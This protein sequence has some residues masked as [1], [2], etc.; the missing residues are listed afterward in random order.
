MASDPVPTS[1]SRPATIGRYRIVDRIGKGAMGIVYSARDETI[2]RQVALKVLMADMESDPLMRER[3]YR[4]ARLAAQLQHR[5]IVTVFD[6]G[7]ED[8]R[9]FIVME[10]LRGSTLGELLRARPTTPLEEKLDL[11]TQVCEGLGLAHARGVYHRDIKPGNLFVQTDGSLKVLDFG[12]ARMASSS[13]TTTG[14]LMGTPDFMAPEQARGEAVDQRSDIFS[15]SAVFYL[16]LSGRKPFDAA[17]LPGVLHNVERRDPVALREDQ[18]PPELSRIVFKGLAKKPADRYQRMSDVLVDLIK[19]R[20]RY[21]AETRRRTVATVTVLTEL[22]AHAGEE[23]ALRG[24]L[25]LPEATDQAPD[26]LAPWRDQ[27]P[28]LAERGHEALST[29]PLRRHQADAM[30]ASVEQA[31]S[32]LDNQTSHLKTAL[33]EFEHAQRLDGESPDAALDHYEQALRACPES[34][35]LAAVLQQCRARVIERQAIDERLQACRLEAQAALNRH[36]WTGAVAATDVGLQLS[37]ADGT[38]LRIRTS[39]EHARQE[40]ERTRQAEL[41]TVAERAVKAIDENRFAEARDLLRR[42][43]TVDAEYAYLTPLRDR[44]HDGERRVEASRALAAEAAANVLRARELFAA[45]SHDA[46]I[47]LLHTFV[48]AHPGSSDTARALEDMTVEAARI[49]ERSRRRSEAARLISA[50][51]A[52]WQRGEAEAALD[53][54]ESA[55]GLDPEQPIAVRIVAEVRAHLRAVAEHEARTRRAQGH[56][57]QARRYL[58]QGRWTAAV[59][60]AESALHLDAGI[61]GAP[62]LIAEARQAEEDAA[63]ERAREAAA[64]RR[65]RAASPIVATARKALREGDRSRAQGAAELALGID[66]DNREAREILD[67][68]AG[69]PVTRG[70]SAGTDRDPDDTVSLV[71][72]ASVRGHLKLGAQ[73]LSAAVG[74]TIIAARRRTQEWTMRGRGPQ[75]PG[76]RSR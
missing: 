65:A 46:A 41:A 62:A 52:A 64:A 55:L 18:A 23:S 72:S 68:F 33:R 76:D 17:D 16:M 66:P 21:D 22:R 4:E 44:L 26:P 25:Q 53:A 42:L 39:A 12:I 24:S 11:M 40:A 2:D 57:E 20:R 74:D 73:K 34:P 6:L 71:P 50:A 29:L 75:S 5:N 1:S 31:R 7:E 45:G 36:D 70:G 14:L 8:G 3:F 51:E 30:A 28:Q 48:A 19:C 56:V 38:L 49:A 67:S 9:P 32:R 58:S 35:M 54:A 37:A 47:D 63:A 60:E 43:E 69:T 10:L 15:A 59:R 61:D 27:Y 13:L